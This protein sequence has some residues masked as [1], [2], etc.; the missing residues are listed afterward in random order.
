[1][2]YCAFKERRYPLWPV[3]GSADL[4]AHPTK[5]PGF[6]QLNLEEFQALVLP[7]ES[8]VPGAYGRGAPR[9][10]VY[11]SPAASFGWTC[12]EPSHVTSTGQS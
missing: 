7:F 10:V 4:Q 3:Y 5:F 1:M 8:R 2:V 6:D 12:L 9:W 11:L